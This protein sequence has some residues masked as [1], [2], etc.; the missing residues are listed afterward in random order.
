MK[1]IRDSI[2]RSLPF[3]KILLK[4][5]PRINKGKLLKRFPDFVA[6]DLVNVIF[7][8]VMGNIPTSKAQIKSLKRHKKSLLHLI[9]QQNKKK[10][11]HFIYK[12]K[13]GF[14]TALLPVI[15][16]LIGGIV[17]NVIRKNTSITN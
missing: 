3:I 2:K 7:N 10:Q 17:G 9:N 5:S 14:L 4:S 8:I 12:Q 6:D 16:S 15:A 13:G 11:R 1:I